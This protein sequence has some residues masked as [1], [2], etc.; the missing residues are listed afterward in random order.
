[1]MHLASVVVVFGG[2]LLYRR[3]PKRHRFVKKL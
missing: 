3:R 1:M 2:Y